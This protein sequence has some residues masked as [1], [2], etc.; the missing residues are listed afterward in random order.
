MKIKCR[1]GWSRG[2]KWPRTII[3]KVAPRLIAMNGSNAL[4]ALADRQAHPFNEPTMEVATAHCSD[5]FSPH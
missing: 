1:Y 2:I 3:A 4:F 5:I